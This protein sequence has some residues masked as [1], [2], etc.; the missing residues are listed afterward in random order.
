VVGLMVCYRLYSIRLSLS[1][2]V[3][4]HTKRERFQPANSRFGQKWNTEAGYVA[5]SR[6]ELFRTQI[7]RSE[8]VAA[9]HYHRSTR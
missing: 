2:K 3:A 8:H 6:K 4:S 7:A 1:L 9:P 5:L